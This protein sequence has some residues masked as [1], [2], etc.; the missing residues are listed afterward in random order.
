MT[1]TAISTD[2]LTSHEEVFGDALPKL[3]AFAVL[4]AGPAT[5]RGLLGPREVPRL[6][7][8]HLLNCAGLS[9]LVSDGEV[10]VD[11]G[12]GAGLPGVV[13]A[14]QRPHV[15]VV[16]VESLERRA[17]FL[18]EVVESLDLRN[19]VVRRARA[20]EL[21]GKLEVDAVT[22]R[23]VAAVDRL[24]ALALPLLHPGGRLLAL[25]GD[26]AQAELEVARPVLTRLGARSSSVVEVGSEALGTRARVVVVEAGQSR[27]SKKG[28]R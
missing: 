7:D 3:E 27:Q 14:C 1:V 8:R 10:V 11:V 13:L 23:A 22:A 15:Q 4:L 18:S 20:E 19:A 24:A 12:S 28:R 25:K 9:S 21:H 5:E 16:L 6:W 17:A 2:N 26:R